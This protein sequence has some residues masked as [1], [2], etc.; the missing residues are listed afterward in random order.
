MRREEGVPP[1]EGED[2]VPPNTRTWIS[3]TI[4]LVLQ[5][6]FRNTHC[7]GGHQRRVLFGPGFRR[8]YEGWHY[9]WLQMVTSNWES[10]ESKSPGCCCWPAGCGGW[11]AGG[12]HDR[13]GDVRRWSGRL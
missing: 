6:E 11:T 5:H 7:V 9:K 4:K 10:V 12:R 3:H 1:E 2:G 8:V 13:S